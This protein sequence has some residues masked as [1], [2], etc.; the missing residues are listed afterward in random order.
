MSQ[1]IIAIQNRY[2]GFI[3]SVLGSLKLEGQKSF[4]RRRFLRDLRQFKSDLEA[5]QNELRQKF[6]E[7]DKEG[8]LRIDGQEY[9][10]TARNRKEFD[11]K[12]NELNEATFNIEVTAGNEKDIA[13]IKEVLIAEIK[14]FE[15]LKKDSFSADD[16]EY[17]SSLKEFTELL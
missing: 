13:D 14:R 9:V 6:V 7:K 15:D 5:E 4:A 11:R 10:F 8:K 17:L 12:W 3:S 2:V 16:F 1:K